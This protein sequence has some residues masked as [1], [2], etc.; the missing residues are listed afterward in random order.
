MKRLFAM[1][2]LRWRRLLGF[3]TWGAIIV[4]IFASA[5]FVFGLVG[6]GVGWIVGLFPHLDELWKEF[7]VFLTNVLCGFFFVTFSYWMVIARTRRQVLSV[8][9]AGVLVVALVSPPQAQ[10]QGSLLAAI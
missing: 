9:L 10:A 8:A 7:I 1:T 6:C 4:V 3:A 5:P 2:S